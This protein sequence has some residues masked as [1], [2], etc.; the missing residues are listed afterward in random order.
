MKTF[1][2]LCVLIGAVGTLAGA[3]ETKLESGRLV[4][5]AKLHHLPLPPPEAKLVLLAHTGSWESV[6]S[7]STS[8]QP[9]IYA[10]AFL[11][12]EKPDGTIEVLRGAKREEIKV[13][14]RNEPTWRSFSTEVL[15][16]KLGGHVSSFS[17]LSTFVCA[18]QAA[19]LGDESTAQ[20]LW[21]VFSQKRTVKDQERLLE[22]CIF[23]HLRDQL[24]EDKVDYKAIRNKMGTLLS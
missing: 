20:A 4:Q 16:P 24:L 9:A 12:A 21:V 15:K 19:A 23:E 1:V 5:I 6:G 2:R 3:E 14:N 18:V 22:H 10:P 17:E 7:K 8:R 13:E 11:L